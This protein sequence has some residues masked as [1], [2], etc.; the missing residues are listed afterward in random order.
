MKKYN[1]SKEVMFYLG[2]NEIYN[3]CS[4]I[5]ENFENDLGYKVNCYIKE[6]DKSIKIISNKDDN[7]IILYFIYDDL[8]F[9]N[10]YKFEGIY[11]ANKYISTKP[12][13][14]KLIKFIS[15]TYLI[16]DVKEPL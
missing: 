2:D 15:N 4:N 5:E 12:L 8:L 3:F 14:T 10:C 9:N 13:I 16:I 11:E 7:S 1:Y 6:N